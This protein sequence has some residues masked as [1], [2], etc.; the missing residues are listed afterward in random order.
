MLRALFSQA[1][2][3][4]VVSGEIIHSW[5]LADRSLLPLVVPVSVKDFTIR[6]VR[7]NGIH[8]SSICNQHVLGMPCILSSVLGGAMSKAWK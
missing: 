2:T 5:L 8:S 1:F 6:S 4:S 7:M 3:K